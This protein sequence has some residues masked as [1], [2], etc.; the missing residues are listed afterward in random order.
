MGSKKRR[1]DGLLIFSLL[2]I[3]ISLSGIMISA[4]LQ[5][6]YA[7]LAFGFLLIAKV[8]VLVTHVL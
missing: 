2:W 1:I 6:M 5:D 8:M 7:L 3:I 4:I